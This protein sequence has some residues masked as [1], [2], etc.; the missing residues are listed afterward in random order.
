[1]NNKEKNICLNYGQITDVM[2]DPIE[3]SVCLEIYE[4]NEV[5]FVHFD[6]YE[7]IKVTTDIF[8]ISN[9]VINDRIKQES[10]YLKKV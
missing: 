6:P 3:G 1:M 10:E 2:H 4:G 5:I 8:R 7:L 9:F